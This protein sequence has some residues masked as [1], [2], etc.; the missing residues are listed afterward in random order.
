LE[1]S[2]PIKRFCQTLR[3]CGLGIETGGMSTSLSGELGHV[4]D[5]LKSAMTEIGKDHE[6][7][8]I[9]KISNACPE[10]CAS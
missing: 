8:L 7:V 3:K 2:E 5:G 6:V 1:L 10:G 4:F 9:V